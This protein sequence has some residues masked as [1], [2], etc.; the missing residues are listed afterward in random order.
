[1]H[2]DIC[3]QFIV[4]A[5]KTLSSIPSLPPLPFFLQSLLFFQRLVHRNSPL[6]PKL[7]H[8]QNDYSSTNKR[9]DSNDRAHPAITDG[10]FERV[11][12]NGAHAGEDVADEVLHG[13]A[14]AGFARQELGEHGGDEREDDHGAAAE[15][16]VCCE[17]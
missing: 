2:S 16:E 8:R 15:E 13:D 1:M 10:M 9:H 14:G 4:L 3:V 7:L 6:I 17:L 11:S 12:K 5:R